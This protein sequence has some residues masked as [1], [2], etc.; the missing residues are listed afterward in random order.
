MRLHELRLRAVG[1]FADEQV[2]DFDRLSAGGLFLFE[3]PTGVGKTT[4]LDALTFALYGGLASE[5]GDAARMRSDFAAPDERPEVTCEF[6]VRGARYRVTRSPEY[7]R[8]KKRGGGSTREKSAVH[9]QQW[10]DGSWVSQSHAKDEVGTLIGELVGL[11][12]AQFRQV[13]LLPQGEFATFLRAD[14]DARKGVLVTLFGTEFFDRITAQLRDRAQEAGRVLDVADSA[15]EARVAAAC[16]AA[17]LSDAVVAQLAKLDGM[18]LL[19]QLEVSGVQVSAEAQAAAEALR[20]ATEAELAAR[21]DLATASDLAARVTRLTGIREALAALEVQRS[22][23]E[24]CGERLVAAQRARAVRPLLQIAEACSADLAGRRAALESLQ[25]A[26]LADAPS[27]GASG[28]VGAEQAGSVCVGLG[29][30]LASSSEQATQ[31][32]QD[33]RATAAGL[34]HLVEAEQSLA[35][36]EEALVSDRQ[37]R[38]DLGAALDSAVRLSGELPGQVTGARAQIDAARV[39]VER[40]SGATSLLATA[41]RQTE[42]ARRV[43]ALEPELE[44]AKQQARE[45]KRAV[46]AAADEHDLLLSTRMTDLRVEIASQLAV[47]DPCGVCGSVEHPAPASGSAHGVSEQHLRDTAA[48]RDEARHV[49]DEADRLV[50]QLDAELASARREAD[51]HTAQEWDAVCAELGELVD[52]GSRARESLPGLAEELDRLVGAEQ[53]ARTDAASLGAQVAALVARIDSVQA[54]VDTA[55]ARVRDGRDGF[56]TVGARVAH[57]SQSAQQWADLGQA[58]AQ[59]ERAA[60]RHAEALASAS[61][62]A[63]ASGFADLEAARAAILEPDDLRALQEVVAQ[64][65]REVATAR[66]QIAEPELVEVADLSTADVLARVAALESAR[67]RT[68]ASAQSA[69]AQHSVAARTQERF[70]ARLDEVR[71]AAEEQSV[72]A[73]AAHEARTLDQYARGMAGDPRMPLATFVL[74]Y[75]F[76]QVVAAANLRLAEMSAGKYQLVRTD[77]GSRRDARVGLGIS[78]LDRHTGKERNP[79]T[80]SG[81]ETFYTSLALALGLTD[82]VVAQAGGAQLDTLFIDEGFGSLDADTLD[83]VM[84]VIDDLRGNGRVVGIVSHVPD[85]KERIS[86]RLTIRRVRRDGPSVVEVLA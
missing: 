74:R 15:L 2:I 22:A 43:Q 18:R 26:V 60:D 32:A 23:H 53:A 57:L 72:L 11:N 7:L 65:D 82:V 21:R 58:L 4:I 34:V 83:D 37:S 38:A 68:S 71:T 56:P 14:D 39:T 13:V 66:A 51:D 73:D 79:G 9:L 24:E 35:D 64:F 8:L 31:R 63:A 5:S 77:S 10:V 84:A 44:N 12:R 28:A 69:H 81:G 48:A 76:E 50:I 67:S 33:L 49:L 16:E 29:G 6:S 62:E 42:A 75:W 61:G 70:A 55:G 25:S 85:L 20:A 19:A 36:Q 27:A 46:G 52:T 86:E 54:Q 59:V 78:V 3:G 41:R 45:A 17:G 40:A 1:P 30:D 80:L 47:G